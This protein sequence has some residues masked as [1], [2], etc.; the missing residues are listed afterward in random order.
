MPFPNEGPVNAAMYA[1][2]GALLIAAAAFL[3]LV[4]FG[5]TVGILFSKRAPWEARKRWVIFSV[6]GTFVALVVS[7]VPFL[8]PLEPDDAAILSFIGVLAAAVANWIP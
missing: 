7:G 5:G 8:L 6:V 2:W 4:F 3:S 1:A